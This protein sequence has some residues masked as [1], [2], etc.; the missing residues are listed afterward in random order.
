MWQM[1]VAAGVMAIGG[2]V[3]GITGYF[4]A[5]EQ[6]ELAREQ[7]DLM[8]Q[9][10]QNQ[11]DM[12]DAQLAF[13]SEIW[14]KW[15]QNFGDTQNE[16]AEYYKNLTDENLKYRFEMANTEA[17]NTL[18]QQYNT[19]MQNLRNQY[20]KQGMQNSGAAITGNIQMQQQL[21]QQR[22]QNSW[23]TQMQKATAM[24]QIMGQKAGWVQQGE[25]LF[26]TSANIINQAYNTN[27]QINAQ[28]ASI[29]AQLANQNKMN[30]ISTWENLGNTIAGMH[31]GYGQQTLKG[32]FD[33]LNNKKEQPDKTQV[34]QPNTTTV[35]IGLT[36]QQTNNYSN[37]NK[38]PN[39]VDY[40]FQNNAHLYPSL[41]RE[42]FNQ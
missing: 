10:M 21:L 16:V 24:E 13:G 1:G 28:M 19:A 2:I 27:G 35:S 7:L 32:Y 40:H 34:T 12:F 5:K 30:S 8:K 31:Y 25:N 36:P 23:Q 41:T 26:N 15:K 9:Q 22:A 4:T 14:D 3:Q 18:L 37:S 6:N 11:K 39:L 42:Y 29:N 20:A 33:S 38:V 17:N